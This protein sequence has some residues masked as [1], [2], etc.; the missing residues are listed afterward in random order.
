[1]PEKGQ[2]IKE[3]F[4]QGGKAASCLIAFWLAVP[5]I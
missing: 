4:I 3:D 5:Q 1:M 2:A